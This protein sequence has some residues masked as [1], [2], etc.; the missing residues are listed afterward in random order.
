MISGLQANTPSFIAY[1]SNMEARLAT[2]TEQLSSGSRVNRPSDDPNAIAPI[3]A[4]QGHI[5]YLTQVQANL[6]QAQTEAQTGDNALQQATSLINQLVTLGSQG[7]SSTSDAS[8]RAILGQKVQAIQQQL[9]NLANS[10]VSG[11]YIFGGDDSGTAPYSYDWS[12]SGGVVQNSSATNTQILRDSDGNTITPR[13]TAQEIFD[14]RNSD[15]T[16]A[17]GNVF[18]AAYALGTALLANNQSGV[19]SAL[20]AVKSASD[21]VSSA[22]TNYGNIE[23]WITTGL[24][25]ATA[26]VNDLTQALGAIRD[27]DIPSLAT[28]LTLNQTAIQAAI[29]ADGSLNTR[30]LFSYLG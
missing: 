25:T 16:P 6:N 29:A 9:V 21:K 26:H 11:H 23:T 17:S 24:Q 12:S 5:N 10:S 18:Q 3:I 20:D 2:V 28:Q 15:G 4:Y 27:A 22:T 1:L 30:S 13:M 14:A 19:Q 7:A 8:S